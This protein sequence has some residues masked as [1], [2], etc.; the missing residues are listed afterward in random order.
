MVLKPFL[1]QLSLRKVALTA[2]I[3][4]YFL[5]VCNYDSIFYIVKLDSNSAMKVESDVEL[6]LSNNFNLPITREVSL[7]RDISTSLSR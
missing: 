6:F 1:L 7:T 3:G 4:E 2:K 5:F